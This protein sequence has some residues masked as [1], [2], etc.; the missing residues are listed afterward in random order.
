MTR[1]LSLLGLIIAFSASAQV[2]RTTDENGNAIFTDNPQHGDAE[3]ITINP[4]NTTPA[5]KVRAATTVAES[6]L[7]Q[8]TPAVADYRVKVTSPEEGST[9]PMGTGSFTVIASV[10]PSL[11]DGETLQ[12]L[13]NGTA[14]GEPQNQNSWNLVNVR[15]GEHS[16]TVARYDADGNVQASSEAVHVLV[17]RPIGRR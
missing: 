3:Q 7:D 5:T 10:S 13:M 12:L 1:T 14:N 6:R 9:I 2:Y 16:I 17:L 8:E 11:E 15:R 4:T